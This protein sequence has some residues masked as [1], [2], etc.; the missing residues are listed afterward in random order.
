MALY[1]TNQTH[2]NINIQSHEY[3]DEVTYMSILG[4]KLIF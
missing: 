4:L 2:T 3:I 1:Q